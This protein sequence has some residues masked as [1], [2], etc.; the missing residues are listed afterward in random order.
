[1]IDSG[2]G[3]P[4]NTGIVVPPLTGFGGTGVGGV[5][6]GQHPLVVG[7]DE[8]VPV[9]IAQFGV[10]VVHPL[11]GG[12]PPLAIAAAPNSSSSMAGLSSCPPALPRSTSRGYKASWMRVLEPMSLEALDLKT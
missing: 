7:S 6:I 2:T 5:G 8:S 1:L 3:A 11:P 12:A 10:V 9:G 4:A